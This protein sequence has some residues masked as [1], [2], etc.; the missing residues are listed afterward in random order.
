MSYGSRHDL[1]VVFHDSMYYFGNRLPTSLEDAV[2][3]LENNLSNDVFEF[4]VRRDHCLEDVIHDMDKLC[5]DPFK[6][7]KVCL[8]YLPVSHRNRD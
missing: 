5:F 1:V 6:R 2:K 7:T 8:P 3:I 4:Q